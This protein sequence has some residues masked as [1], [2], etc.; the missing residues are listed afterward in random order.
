VFVL[1]KRNLIVLILPLLVMI[2]IIYSGIHFLDQANVMTNEELSET[3]T[4]EVGFEQKDHV[5]E[6]SGHWN[7]NDIPQDIFVGDDYI[8]VSVMDES[9]NLVED[10]FKQS[11]VQLLHNEEVVYEVAGKQT[12]TGLIFAFPNKFENHKG[13]GNQGNFT[14]EINLPQFEQG[15]QFVA[16]YLHTWAEHSG[17][18]ESDPRFLSPEFKENM[19]GFYWVVERFETGELNKQ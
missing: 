1:I 8:G 4:F 11:T 19:D 14:V 3:M 17:L 2:F 16:S 5:I 9:G 18:V 13:Y 10:L 7:W 12:D 6:V 15:W